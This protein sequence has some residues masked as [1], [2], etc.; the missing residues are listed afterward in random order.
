MSDWQ[1]MD[2]DL[3]KSINRLKEEIKNDFYF[4]TPCGFLVSILLVWQNQLKKLGIF[5]NPQWAF[6]LFNDFLSWRAFAFVL[7]VYAILGFIFRKSGYKSKKLENI[8][9]HINDRL[10]QFGSSIIC[11]TAGFSLFL[12]GL[13]IGTADSS[14]ARALFITVSFSVFISA[15]IILIELFVRP[16]E[17]FD[18]DFLIVLIV[19][20]VTYFAIRQVGS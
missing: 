9:S 19:L 2:S 13:V 11:F 6:D 3:K 16:Q 8:I 4:F 17:N 14:A 5:E 7:F 12:F 1:Y 10:H 20:T 15:S 18:I